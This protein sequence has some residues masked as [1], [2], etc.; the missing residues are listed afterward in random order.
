MDGVLN[1]KN[2]KKPSYLVSIPEHRKLFG[3]Y[4]R[5][6]RSNGLSI[7]PVVCLGCLYTKSN[8]FMRLRTLVHALSQYTLWSRLPLKH[9]N[10]PY[11]VLW[12]LIGDPID[13]VDAWGVWP[14]PLSSLEGM[15]SVIGSLKL[16]NVR[17]RGKNVENSQFFEY[18]S[19]FLHS[20]S[21]RW[22]D[23]L[24]A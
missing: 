17:S 1:L 9:Q 15:G 8:I 21:K 16:K 14:S 13:P 4:G 2:A 18:Y 7:D 23:A 22:F 3:R 11:W 12:R 10:G 19:V 20:G 24:G 5:L 6:R